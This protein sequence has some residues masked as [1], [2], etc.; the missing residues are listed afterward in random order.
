MHDVLHIKDLIKEQIKLIEPI[1]VNGTTRKIR[2]S[3]IEEISKFNT[4]L[5]SDL[6]IG[7]FIKEYKPILINC[8]MSMYQKLNEE[9]RTLPTFSLKNIAQEEAANIMKIWENIEK[10]Q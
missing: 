3:A 1:C 6:S 5:M 4:I 2:I 7:D 9:S 10:Y 8:C